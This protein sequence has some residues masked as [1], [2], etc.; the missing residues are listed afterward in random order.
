M[1][2]QNVL[3]SIPFFT[4]HCIYLLI[5]VCEDVEKRVR[6]FLWGPNIHL[7]KTVTKDKSQGGLGIR[8]LNNMNKAFMEKMGWRLIT[9]SQTLWAQIL[10]AKYMQRN[11]GNKV[12]IWKQGDSNLWKGLCIAYDILKKGTKMTVRS[13]RST[14]F[15]NDRWICDKPLSHLVQGSVPK[16][17]TRKIVVDYWKSGKGWDWSVLNDLLRE[18]IRKTLNI[19]NLIDDD[20][21]PDEIYWEQDS[22]GS[23]IVSPAYKLLSDDK[24]TNGISDWDRIWKLKVPNRV[25]SFLWLLKHKRLMCNVERRRRGFT[26]NDHCKTCHGIEEDLDHVFRRCV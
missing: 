26:S 9:N 4:M 2:A 16:D 20:T 15:W 12:F 10:R 18:D 22:S 14:N 5:G 6:K 19:F 7:V 3:S 11:N 8:N 13:G 17:E 21:E 1:L 24:S 23:V 25:C